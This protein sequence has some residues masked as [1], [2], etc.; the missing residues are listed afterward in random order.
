MGVKIH[1]RSAIRGA[2][3]HALHLH[4]TSKGW[5]VQY[6]GDK[7]QITVVDGPFGKTREQDLIA[8]YT[9]IQVSSR[10][11]ALEWSR[12]F[13]NPVGHGKPAQ[14]EVR[15][16][17]EMEDFVQGEGVEKFREIDAKLAAEKTQ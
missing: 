15:Q 7:D 12:R 4:P 5:R 16:V 9:L 11:E 8:G 13:P 17:F 14:I 3:I 1:C 2:A 10:E 6:S